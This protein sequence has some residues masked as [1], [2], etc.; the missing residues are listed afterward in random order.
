M[1][2]GWNYKSSREYKNKIKPNPNTEIIMEIADEKQGYINWNCM[3]IE[4]IMI[5]PS[6][7]EYKPNLNKVDI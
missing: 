7:F 2:K 5:C 3:K 1:I 4:I 6:N